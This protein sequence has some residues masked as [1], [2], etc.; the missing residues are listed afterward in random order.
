MVDPYHGVVI[1]PS[2]PIRLG[3]IAFCAL[4]LISAA[5]TL[6]GQMAITINT[7][8]KIEYQNKLLIAALQETATGQIPIK[9]CT[10]FNDT[11]VGV[12][13]LN[14]NQIIVNPNITADAKAFNMTTLSVITD[15]NVTAMDF[16]KNGVT[17][18]V[19][20]TRGCECVWDV[21]DTAVCSNGDTVDSVASLIPDKN[22]CQVNLAPS[23]FLAVGQMG[24][25]PDDV[26]KT[27][28]ITHPA[29]V[30][31]G[32]LFV[33]GTHAIP[34]T[35][36]EL[37]VAFNN[38][39]MFTGEDLFP[40]GYSLPNSIEEPQSPEQLFPER[41][42]V[43]ATITSF[44]T[45]RGGTTIT[46]ETLRSDQSNIPTTC[47]AGYPIN[48]NPYLG[49][50][51]QNVT[52][53]TIHSIPM[54]QLAEDILRCGNV[55]ED[56]P[57]KLGASPN[58]VFNP[59][60]T[61]AT[62]PIFPLA[63]GATFE[64]SWG[65]ELINYS[66]VKDDDDSGLAESGAMSCAHFNVASLDDDETCLKDDE[67]RQGQNGGS[68]S[69]NDLPSN[70]TY[71]GVPHG[72][73]GGCDAQGRKE[74]L[75]PVALQLYALCF[76]VGIQQGLYT[77]QTGLVTDMFVTIH[78][79]NPVII[80]MSSGPKTHKM[81]GHSFMQVDDEVFDLYPG[82]FGQCAMFS[83]ATPFYF[84]KNF[85]EATPHFHADVGPFTHP[86]NSTYGNDKYYGYNHFC[87]ASNIMPAN[88]FIEVKA[89]IPG[90]RERVEVVAAGQASTGTF[91]INSKRGVAPLQGPYDKIS[92]MSGDFWRSYVDP[93]TGKIDWAKRSKARAAPQKKPVE[94]KELLERYRRE[95][96]MRNGEGV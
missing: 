89:T 70:K 71:T 39:R 30:F 73:H 37:L 36:E 9:E 86:L 56:L 12:F 19:F 59:S 94:P 43:D 28:H 66:M 90:L 26:L 63:R 96:L 83:A 48:P 58:D 34:G 29:V 24:P 38:S 72:R 15:G 1:S 35:I 41:F 25:S 14:G 50:N 61:W 78:H 13:V 4:A 85:A 22:V 79:V 23:Q 51:E 20:A 91:S 46:T 27:L 80:D 11:D 6:F 2:I 32:T 76:G 88:A 3:V 17:C 54:S 87:R 68:S 33:N 57:V 82:Y 75:G 45:P 92:A 84:D 62:S 60:R 95:V 21:D 69:P 77:S 65:T 49:N 64:I 74:N 40:L 93:A 42:P 55:N 53:E 47:A 8:D 81:R 67:I 5:A 10:T 7:R 52:A 16:T 31:N 44:Y 18:C